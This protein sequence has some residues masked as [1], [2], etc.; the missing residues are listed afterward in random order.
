[1]GQISMLKREKVKKTF[2]G[3][4]YVVETLIQH[5]ADINHKYSLGKYIMVKLCLLSLPI[6]GQ[7]LGH[8]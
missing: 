7:V 6:I 8:T 1:M 2:Y 3:L 5:E 4:A